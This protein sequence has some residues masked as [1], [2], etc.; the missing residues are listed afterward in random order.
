MK[1]SFFQFSN[2]QLI[3]IEFCINK[4]FK[5]DLFK[6]FSI[7]SNV[8]KR[9][10]E[11]ETEAMVDLD[12]VIGEKDERYPFYISI[13]MSGLFRCDKKANFDKFLNP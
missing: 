3:N 4:N 10:I 11:E 7:E 6:G 1:E 9:I 13:I 5:E 2:P 8:T 12:L